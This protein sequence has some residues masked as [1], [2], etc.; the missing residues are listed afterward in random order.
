MA[1]RAIPAAHAETKLLMAPDNGPLEKRCLKAVSRPTLTAGGP[2][3]GLR[4]FRGSNAG[5]C[6]FYPQ[7]C[8][9][10]SR[11]THGQ[12][13]SRLLGVAAGLEAGSSLARMFLKLMGD[14]EIQS[15]V[16]SPAFSVCF[17]NNLMTLL[18]V[19]LP[20]AFIWKWT[21]TYAEREE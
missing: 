4:G 11:G 8:S 18:S 10:I 17:A 1:E 20:V 6:S 5:G 15:N 14:H 3:R 2:A 9:V 12:Q 16:H 21:Q 19:L 7:V 13:R